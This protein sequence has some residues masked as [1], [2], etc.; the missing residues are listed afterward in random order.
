[1]CESTIVDLVDSETR[2]KSSSLPVS[3]TS[4]EEDDQCRQ[5]IE[6][7]D[8]DDAVVS[9]S[10]VDNDDDDGLSV[11]SGKVQLDIS[12]GDKYEESQDA[13]SES[14]RSERSNASEAILS[15]RK[16][17]RGLVVEDK[18]PYLPVGEYVLARPLV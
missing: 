18:L 5:A 13:K 14:G 15:S 16:I 1:M 8:E 17:H 10:D 7:D 12:Q 11:K 9:V 4:G 6:D 3:S 2:G